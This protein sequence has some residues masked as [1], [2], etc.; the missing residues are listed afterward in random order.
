[1]AIRQPIGINGHAQTV[2][3]TT[4]LLQRVPQIVQT[5]K[6]GRCA[7][8]RYRAARNALCKLI[9]KIESLVVNFP[10]RVV[11]NQDILEMI[12]KETKKRR[13][14]VGDLDRTLKLVGRQLKSTGSDV[15]RWRTDGETSLQLTI[16][17][18]KKAMDGLQKG[19]RIDLLIMASV[20][21]E[22]VEPATSNL[23][24]HEIGLDYVECFDVKEA[25]DGWMKAVKIASSFIESGQYKRIMVVNPEFVMTEG[26][27]IY[28]DLFNLPSPEVL[29]HRFPAFTLGEAATAMVLGPDMDNVWKFT[30]H[31]RNDL[32]D[33]CSI[34]SGWNGSDFV[35]SERVAKNGAGKFVSY[36]GKL[37]ED[38]F[39]L[40][41]DQ[42]KIAAIKATDV[43]FTH[44]SSKKD[45]SEGASVIGLKEE[46]YD[47]YTRYG[48]VVSAAVPA[49]MALAFEEGK[50]KRGHRVAT[51]VAS[52]GMSFSTATFTF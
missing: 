42:F 51:W 40:A 11:S 13:D 30:N 23:I 29:E 18:C 46:F 41:I 26:F 3:R 16:D 1:M 37:R 12:S 19:E 32:Y 20:Y 28:P 6:F 31:T 25:C 2:A 50:L 48:N 45:W 34:T 36:G 17:A 39:P 22:L 15:R 49:A 8:E 10:S 43:L 44:S 38:G 27:G 24:A 35:K 14:F 52:A 47:I 4:T 9:V 21:S 5:G 33:L 7:P